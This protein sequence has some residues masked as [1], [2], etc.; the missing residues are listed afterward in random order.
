MAEMIKNLAIV[1]VM[2]VVVVAFE[3]LFR[4]LRKNRL[5]RQLVSREQPGRKD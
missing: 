4:L 5:V 2:T 3:G 1:A